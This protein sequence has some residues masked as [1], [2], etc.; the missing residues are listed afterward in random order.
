MAHSPLLASV[1]VRALQSAPELTALNIAALK[2]V[3][4]DLASL[5]SALV[6][7]DVSHTKLSSAAIPSLL[8]LPLATSL[9]ALLL[10]NTT[11]GKEDALRCFDFPALR[12]LD[13]SG[14]PAATAGVVSR[15]QSTPPPSPPSQSLYRSLGE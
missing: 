2:V 4:S 8:N 5:P 12:L 13:L 10:A 11:V 7:L 1:A 15:I 9:Q 6:F 3:D 14:T